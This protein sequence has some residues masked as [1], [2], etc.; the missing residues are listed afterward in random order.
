M[1]EKHP[2]VDWEGID[3]QK[4]NEGQWQSHILQGLERLHQNESTLI[5][6]AKGNA[7]KVEIAGALRKTTTAKNRWIAKRLNMGHPSPVSKL[8]SNKA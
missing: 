1:A 7:W 4:L 5:S 2:D 3:L 6:E 8:I